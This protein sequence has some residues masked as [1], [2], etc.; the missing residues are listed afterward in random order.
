[1]LRK[2]PLACKLIEQYAYEK[3]AI[4]SRSDLFGVDGLVED[5]RKT[6][7]RIMVILLQRERIT[8]LIINRICHIDK[9]DKLVIR[10]NVRNISVD[11]C[12]TP[13]QRGWRYFEL[14]YDKRIIKVP[15]LFIKYNM[16]VVKALE[17]EK[18]EKAS[19]REIN[20]GIITMGVLFLLTAIM[21]I[22]ISHMKYSFLFHVACFICLIVTTFVFNFYYDV[23]IAH[24]AVQ[25]DT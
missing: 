7:M 14:F 22:I 16:V 5:I 11:L 1:M 13:N 3:A 10:K 20:F 18:I 17:R 21:V 12:Y 24:A 8:M 6:I 2:E 23:F 4:F 19:T 15:R 9:K 25:V